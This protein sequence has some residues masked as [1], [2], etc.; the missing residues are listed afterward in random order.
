M[1][2]KKLLSWAL[3]SGAK[4]SSH[5]PSFVSLDATGGESVTYESLLSHSLKLGSAFRQLLFEKRELEAERAAT[6]TATKSPSMVRFSDELH[7]GAGN[8]QDRKSNGNLHVNGSVGGSS[9][10]GGGGAMLHPG[11]KAGPS[12]VLG[13]DEPHGGALDPDSEKGPLVALVMADSGELLVSLFAAAVS[14]SSV[15]MVNTRLLP[16]PAGAVREQLALRK[17]DIIIY[18]P[19][20]VDLLPRDL[21][22]AILVEAG[23]TSTETSTTGLHRGND[24]LSMWDLIEASE[25]ITPR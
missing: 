3:L 6:F 20:T 1:L 11:E 16:D 14:N 15:F 24:V 22:G 23:L 17:P 5:A 12:A 13:D 2:E 25:P 7:S 19:A 9:G 10:G 4:R 8:A 18:S 21:E